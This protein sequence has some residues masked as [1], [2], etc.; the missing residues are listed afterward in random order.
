MNIGKKNIVFA[1]C[2]FIILYGIIVLFGE[3]Y[4]GNLSYF[5]LYLLISV[6]LYIFTISKSKK[7]EEKLEE[8]INS[9]YKQ[10][11]I[12]ASLYN[13]LDIKIPLPE[14]GGWAAQP[15]FSKKNSRNYPT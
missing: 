1:L 11:E 13:Y 6:G 14:T 7:L 5:I 4:L 12:L 3:Q 9:K 2:I 8:D 15:D 10:L